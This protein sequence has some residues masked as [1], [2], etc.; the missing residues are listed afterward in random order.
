MSTLPN[1]NRTN[2]ARDKIQVLEHWFL[3]HLDYPYPSETEKQL[4]ERDAQVNRR[5]LDNWFMN[6][7]CFSLWY[8]VAYSNMSDSHSSQT[9]QEEEIRS[10]FDASY[11][12][13]REMRYQP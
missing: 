12:T 3:L 13:E 9:R 2:I 7:M 11:I 4:L 6:G 5:Q 1:S 10:G 8:N